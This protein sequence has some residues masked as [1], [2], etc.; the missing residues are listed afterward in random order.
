MRRDIGGLEHI[1]WLVW[2]GTGDERVWIGMVG[3]TRRGITTVR[4]D[5]P[6]ILPKRS[7]QA[8]GNVVAVN[9]IAVNVLAVLGMRCHLVD[10]LLPCVLQLR[11]KVNIVLV[12]GGG[13]FPELL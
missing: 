7:S 9:V 12:H 11:S 8:T 2:A 6:Y 3:K 13:C 1:E 5:G 4:C 10:D